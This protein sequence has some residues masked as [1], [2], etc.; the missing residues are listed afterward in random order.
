MPVYN[1]MFTIAFTVVSENDGEHVTEQ[2]LLDGLANRLQTLAASGN[3]EIVEAVGLPDDTHI[4][5]E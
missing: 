3:D 5:E 1:H 4:E 2:E